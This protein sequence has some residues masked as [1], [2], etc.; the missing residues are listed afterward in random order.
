DPSAGA[1]ASAVSGRRSSLSFMPP[2]APPQSRRGL[3]DF[4]RRIAAPRRD[5]SVSTPDLTTISPAA[6]AS[7]PDLRGEPELSKKTGGLLD[8]FKPKKTAPPSIEII[9][10]SLGGG[11]SAQANAP[12]N[13]VVTSGFVPW[14]YP[15]NIGDPVTSHKEDVLKDFNLA[16]P[17]QAATLQ[18]ADATEQKI[19]VIHLL[20]HQREKIPTPADEQSEYNPLTHRFRNILPMKT[21][22]ISTSAGASIGV[23]N[24]VVEGKVVGMACSL[25][26]DSKLGEMYNFMFEH[27]VQGVHVIMQDSDFQKDDHT[28]YF[29]PQ[30]TSSD[31]QTIYTRPSSS[32]L[33]DGFRIN[34]ATHKMEFHDVGISTSSGRLKVEKVSELVYDRGLESETKCFVL[35]LSRRGVEQQVKVLHSPNWVDQSNIPVEVL[36]RLLELREICF[37]TFSPDR[38][39]THCRAGVGRTGTLLA[40]EAMRHLPGSNLTD[41]VLSLRDS[42]NFQMVQTSGQLELLME[43]AERYQYPILDQSSLDPANP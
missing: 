23:N 8:R 22:L 14:N 30:R 39:L 20:N 41:I 36:N 34:A 12:I 21:T 40:A 17:A 29:D 24:M 4:F 11:G 6:G 25:P 15:Q 5:K 27:V 31:P 33:F 16:E 18:S 26:L 37:D 38:I 35:K 19:A 28:N 43:L 7:L 10:T 32:F 9:H 3:R 13:Q 2:S 42:R 1:A